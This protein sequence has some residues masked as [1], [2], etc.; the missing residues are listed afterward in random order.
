MNVYIFKGIIRNTFYIIKINY[1]IQN[2]LLD[3]LWKTLKK[4]LRKN[5][6]LEAWHQGLYKKYKKTHDIVAQIIDL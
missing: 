2:W 4:V 1:Q 5:S 3:M 6:S